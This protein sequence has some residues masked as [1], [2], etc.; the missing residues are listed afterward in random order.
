MHKRSFCPTGD[1]QM[2]PFSPPRLPLKDLDWPQLVP[3]LGRANRAVARY[4][5]LLHSLPN[6]DILLAPLTTQ[7]AVLSSRIEGTQ[8]TLEEVLR[9]EADR[10][11]APPRGDVQEI[12]NYRRALQHAAVALRRYPLSLNLVREIHALLLEG[13]RG[14][15]SMRGRFRTVQ[16]WIGAPGTPIEEATY[17]PPPPDRIPALL[18]NWER[19]LHYEEKDRL[20]QLAVAHAQFEL[21]HP[22]LDGNGRVG[23]IL[24]PLFLYEKRI[25]HRPVL[26][27]SEYFERR[28]D[29]YYRYLQ[30][31]SDGADWEA[32]ILFFLHAIVDQAHRNNEKARAIL[33]L[34]EAMKRRLPEVTRSPHAIRALDYLFQQPVFRTAGLAEKLGISRQ[35]AI[36]LAN[37]LVAEQIVDEIAQASGRRGALYMFSRLLAIVGSEA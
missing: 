11:S 28:R 10:A 36:R 20:V 3:V 31:L 8:A 14:H 2:P 35:T 13:G 18:D 26:Y 32:W 33:D 19:Y 27:L 1:T 34:Y 6:P 15:H 12:L 29:E 5:G 30:G 22:F 16:N 17:V 23:R 7:E 24:I 37:R 25:L 21:I 4:D 9:Y